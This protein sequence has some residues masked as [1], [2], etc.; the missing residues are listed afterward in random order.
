MSLIVIHALQNLESKDKSRLTEILKMK[1][2]NREL[3]EEA[4]QLLKSSKSIQYAQSVAYKLVDEAWN[5]VKRIIPNSNSKGYLKALGR[6]FID[7][8]L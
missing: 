1:T 4:I 8:N 5:D 2:N 6:F 7:R 3:I